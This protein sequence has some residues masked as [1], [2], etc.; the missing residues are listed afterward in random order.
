MANDTSIHRTT[1]DTDISVP[2]K[3]PSSESIDVSKLSFFEE[4]L[5]IGQFESS[6]PDATKLPVVQ[7][8]SSD[9][10]SESK[11]SS[12]APEDSAITEGEDSNEPN[13]A[14]SAYAAQVSAQQQL[15][16]Q[17]QVQTSVKDV[18][19]RDGIAAKPTDKNEDLQRD[20]NSIAAKNS[21]GEESNTRRE[22]V[23]TQAPDDTENSTQIASDSKAIRIEQQPKEIDGNPQSDASVDTVKSKPIKASADASD[24]NA[25]E[26]QSGQVNIELSLVDSDTRT[27]RST[28]IS[29]T[30]NQNSNDE[31]IDVSP[32]QTRNK[33]AERLAK[34]ST[35]SDPVS[36]ERDTSSE[37]IHAQAHADEAAKT[38]T[39]SDQHS[40]SFASEQKSSSPITNILP[41]IAPSTAFNSSIPNTT[42]SHNA[43]PNGEGISAI[44]T[45]SLR[46]GIQTNTSNT[47]STTFT[48]S[49]SNPARAEQG[50]V[51]VARSNAGPHISAYQETKLVQRVLRG[52]EQLANGG[53][54]VRLRLHPPELGSLQMSLRMEDGQVFAKL[55]VENSTA[56][57]ALLNNIQTLRDRLTEQGMRVAAFEVEVSTDSAGL[58]TGGSNYQ[59][60]G[61]TQS[62]SSWNNA[63][64]RFAQQKE[65]RLPSEPR[66]PER[67]PGAAW[68]RTSGSIDLT[69]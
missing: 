58:G 57:D 11:S 2:R 16:P 47:S 34:Q 20:D 17:P 65:N 12:T 19:D 68:T 59:G 8:N 45:S 15:T 24:A 51:E 46:G 67:K 35:E 61:G 38:E 69:V 55:E 54:Q 37:T 1:T 60:D 28:D 66:P 21:K 48:G 9:I 50:R 14:Q 13:A 31:N 49:A 36:D 52:V 64:S 56:R 7:R 44:A 29:E 62:Q 39:P 6:L 32:N 41:V 18:S 42:T 27:K 10:G 26:K 3:K 63:T 5:S 22:I 30:A 25:D 43:R 53:G 23:K 33:R 4:L 40:L